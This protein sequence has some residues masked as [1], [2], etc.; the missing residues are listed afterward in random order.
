M[1]KLVYVKKIPCRGFKLPN[2]KIFE[3][4][5]CRYDSK[6]DIENETY[7][8]SY[9]EDYNKSS[10]PT[11]QELVNVGIIKEVSCIE[12][13][14]RIDFDKNDKRSIDKVI[15]YTIEKFSENGFNVTE[16]AIRHNFNAWVLDMKSGYRDEKNNYHLFTPCGC[17]PLSFSA[18]TLHEQCEDWQKTY[19][20]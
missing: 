17:N 9:E 6:I 16:E 18:T 13:S 7:I 20:C 11:I 15:K 3:L 1:E 14:F 5:P 8:L 10:L 19:K 2:G 4:F 12:K